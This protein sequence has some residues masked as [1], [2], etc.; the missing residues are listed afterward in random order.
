MNQEYVYGSLKRKKTCEAYQSMVRD[1]V[2]EAEWK[3]SDV[4]EHWQQ[5]KNLMMATA[6]D[7]CGM[8]KGP[9]RTVIYSTVLL[10]G[11]A[12]CHQFGFLFHEQSV[13]DD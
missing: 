13:A 12:T 1:K 11:P 2:E 4:N 6:K 7:V 3:Y 5:M 10:T 8:S 9:C